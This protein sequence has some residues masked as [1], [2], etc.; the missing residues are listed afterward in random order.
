MTRRARGLL[1]MC[2]VLYMGRTVGI[3]GKVEAYRGRR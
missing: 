2:N 1:T 3:A